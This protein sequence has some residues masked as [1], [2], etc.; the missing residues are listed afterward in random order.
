MITTIANA[1]SMPW[2]SSTVTR[3]RPR[4]R[5]TPAR[6]AHRPALEGRPARGLDQDGVAGPQDGRAGAA[7]AAS[8]SAHDVD[9]ARVEAGRRAPVGDPRPPARRRPRAP[10]RPGPRRR[11]TSRWPA[12]WPAPSSSI[13]PST[14]TGGPAASARPRGRRRIGGRRGVVGVVE[15]RQARG[16]HDD[17]AVGRARP[18]GRREAGRDRSSAQAGDE[19]RRPPR[20]ARSGRCAGPGRRSRLRR[21]PARRPATSV[22]RHARRPRA[23]TTASARDVGAGPRP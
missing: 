14:A 4:R 21:A 12:S 19:A 3:G 22:E 17:A 5:P 20:P 13:S 23:T 16:L 9:A 7:R 11:P 2:I 10:P 8:R 18:H 1:S 6:Q 15:D